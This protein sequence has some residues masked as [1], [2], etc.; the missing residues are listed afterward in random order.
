[1]QPARR[2]TT[3]QLTVTNTTAN[4]YQLSQMDDACIEQFV[5]TVQTNDA[6]NTTV[7]N[8]IVWIVRESDGRFVRFFTVPSGTQVSWVESLP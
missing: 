5:T 2:G 6:Y 8:H 1:M 3:A 7:G 4:V